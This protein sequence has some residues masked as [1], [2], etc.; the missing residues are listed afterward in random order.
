MNM[1]ID[2]YLTYM[3]T[4]NIVQPLYYPYV[5]LIE[6]HPYFLAILGNS[7]PISGESQ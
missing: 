6:F 7:V 1:I 3:V 4:V 5:Y 2:V